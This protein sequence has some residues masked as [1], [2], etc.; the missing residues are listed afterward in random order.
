MELYVYLLWT[1]GWLERNP[2]PNPNPKEGKREMFRLKFL[3]ELYFE[4]D[5]GVWGER[6][7]ISRDCDSFVSDNTV[8]SGW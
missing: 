7:C 5:E 4:M 6:G 3:F 8:L 2:K 1:I